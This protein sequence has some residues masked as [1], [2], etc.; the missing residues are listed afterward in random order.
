[1]PLK[2]ITKILQ[3]DEL[4]RSV[5]VNRDR[6]ICLFLGAGASISSGMP[7][8]QRCIWEWKQDIFITNNPLLRESVSE[9]SLPG[10]RQRIQQW[11][12]QR[13]EYPPLDDPEEY[14][15]YAAKC[16][17]TSQDR[18]AFFQSYVSKAQPHIGYRL[19]AKLAKIGVIQTIWTTNFDGLACN[20]A[21]KFDVTCIEVGI[22]TAFRANRPAKAGELRVVSLHGDY[23]YDKLKNTAS[24]LQEQEGLLRDE[25]LHELQDYDLIVLGYSGRDASVMSLLE[26]TY[27]KA[28]DCRLFWCGFG[29]SIPSEVEQ[30]LNK[31]GSAG[32]EAFY[33]PTEGFDDVISRF[34]LRLMD[35][36]S[37]KEVQQM[38]SDFS[39]GISGPAPFLSPE[40]TPTS[41]I[42][43]N[44][45]PLII[46]H[47]ALKGTLTIPPGIKPRHWLNDKWGAR[48]GTIVS[49]D[50]GVLA[51]ADG[52]TLMEAFGSELVNSPVATAVSQADVLN[53]GRIL[54]LYRRALVT[55]LANKLRLKS[56]MSRRIWEPVS[57]DT[58]F[59]N[60]INYNLHKALALRIEPV[61]GKLFVTLMPEIM[62][63]TPSGELAEK[64]I[65]KIV[66]SK[67]Y[68]SQYN[69]VFDTE[70]KNW[71]A[72]ICGKEIL[73]PSGAY[74]KIPAS[75]S[76][77]GLIQAGQA[78]LPREVLRFAHQ[79]GWIIPDAPL[80]FTSSNGKSE[81]KDSNPLRGLVL[82]KPWD[83]KLTSSAL[84]PEVE[85]GAICPQSDA[86]K[87]RRFLNQFHETSK[88]DSK[89][90]DYL[91]DFPGFTSAF[92]LPLK[93]PVPGDELW[94]GLD[95]NLIGE[96][97]NAAKDLAQR[98]CRS[99]DVIRSLR[100]AAV[101]AIFVPFRWEPYERIDSDGERFDLHNF[102]KAYA[103]R[104]G[105]ST[106]F[107][108]EKTTL[109]SQ[110]CRTRW[111][112][113]L[114]LYAKAQRTPWRLD[115]LDDETAF[116]GLGYS[117]DSAASLGNH[118]LLGCSHLYNARGEGLQFRLGRIE[119][120]V[121]RKGNPF[122]SL[123]DSRRMGETIRQLFYDAKMK[124]PSRVVIHKRTQFTEE[125]QQGLLQG[126]EGVAN[127]ELI[128]ICV[129]ESIRYLA[130][131][132]N[133]GQLQID[134]FPIPRGA[135]VSLD[136]NT[137]LL[138]V[139]GVTPNTQNPRF[140]YYQGKRRIPA[141]LLIR[142]YRGHSDV[143]QVATEIL[144]LTK[145]NWNSFDY[146]SR[147]PSTIDSANSIAR[148]GDYLSGMPSSSYDY[149]HLI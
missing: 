71:T 73:D 17:P 148:Y 139:H 11:L 57:Y 117:V 63:F 16:Y 113:S 10:T 44:A 127:V 116:V 28:G 76:C 95:D 108:R 111:W 145:M 27:S 119:N 138:W 74:F 67:V 6:P 83:Y 36:S 25:F 79:K 20:A 123:D 141:P 38:M 91:R 114:A 86:H 90:S 140:K 87:L 59:F 81:V 30:L 65:T 15:F 109:G 104:H 133:N 112:L 31:A 99:L 75:P 149:R 55:N 88:A 115:C 72:K 94:L 48:P 18:R 125:E 106:Q 34:A 32:R 89:E 19:I 12:D 52:Q 147:L 131:K 35:S 29:S 53:D 49:V 60:G 58:H 122:M 121:F 56:D 23:R 142:R 42:K 7:S 124:L 66:R 102:V 70:I 107:I 80:V 54:S 103:A 13:A 69:A 47:T 85:M 143:T 105:Q 101:V 26:E 4:V 40:Q 9:L 61:G 8:G 135:L 144:G 62:V 82:N 50:G 1:M 146:Y 41:L 39:S 46:P 3:I 14:S 5:A 134:T 120:P 98:I 100:P 130:S 37:L 22:D 77:A 24:E 2:E 92:A 126:L 136:K 129:S 110:A 97:I 64:D 43:S 33:V 68:A 96:P 132:V 93:S 21:A 128:E 78:P 137:A 51:L 45:Y 118:I 84:C